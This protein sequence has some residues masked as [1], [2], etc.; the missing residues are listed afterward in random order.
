MARVLDL[1]VEAAQVA[2]ELPDSF[3]LDDVERGAALGTWLQRMRNEHVSARVFAAL[4]GQMMKAGSPSSDIS[5]VASMIGEE[6]EHGRLCAAV[7]LAL[8]GEP[9]MPVGHLE[10]VP[11]HDDAEPLEALL[12]NI[13][14]ISCLSETVAV[15]LIDAEHQEAGPE[16]LQRILREILADEVKHARFGWKLLES[17]QKDLTPELRGRLGDYLVEAFL[18]LRQHELEFLP[19]TPSPSEKAAEYGVCDGM[20]AR[21]LFFDTVD[22]VIIPRLEEFGIPARDAWRASLVLEQR[23]AAN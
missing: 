2:L 6:L 16:E 13:I 22:S 14:S 9:V 11:T 15:A 12:R 20:D 5:M 7:V 1:S 3:E 10:D 23:L 17:H 19:P 18:H 21:Q 4:V 8:G